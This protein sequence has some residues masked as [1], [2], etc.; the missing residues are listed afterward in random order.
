MIGG[1]LVQAQVH[2]PECEGL[3]HPQAGLQHDPEGHA[4]RVAG[5]AL[6]E[7]GRLLRS[8][9]VRDLLLDL[10]WHPIASQGIFATCGPSMPAILNTF[11][12][13]AEPGPFHQ[14]E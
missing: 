1:S 7:G 2:A 12:C 5:R 6:H 3:G 8:E 9:V 14:R 11:R 13:K 4:R 10:S